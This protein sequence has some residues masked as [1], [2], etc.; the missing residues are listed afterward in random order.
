MQNTSSD[1]KQQ[2]KE[3]ANIFTEEFIKDAESKINPNESPKKKFELGSILVNSRNK[4]KVLKGI[5]YLKQLLLANDKQIDTLYK[6]DCLYLIA[7][8]YFDIE[9][10]SESN[11]LL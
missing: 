1:L 8:G 2:L 9:D 3:E 5:Q 4:E 11:D 6:R 10:Y 7:R